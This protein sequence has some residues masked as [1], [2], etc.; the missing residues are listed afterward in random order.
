MK[1]SPGIPGF[2]DEVVQALP[3]LLR[4]FPGIVNIGNPDPPVGFREGTVM[5][6]RS[7]IPADLGE[8]VLRENIFSGENL[9][10]GRTDLRVD[11]S[12]TVQPDQPLDV[13]L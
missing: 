12:V 10:H 11:Q 8:N 2:P 9:L 1:R 7:L 4:P 13:R 5:A 3:E 6:P